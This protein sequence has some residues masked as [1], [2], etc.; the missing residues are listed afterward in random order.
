MI[1]NESLTLTKKEVNGLLAVL[2]PFANMDRAEA[3]DMDELACERGMA[4]DK[5]I[6]TTGDFRKL[7]AEFQKIIKTMGYSGV[8]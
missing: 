2:L 8:V 1:Y 4:S 6:I 5:T 7:R 3:V